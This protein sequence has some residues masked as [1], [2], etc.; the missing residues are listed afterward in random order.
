MG[1]M[2]LHWLVRKRIKESGGLLVLK[3]LGVV[4]EGL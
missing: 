3:L 2:N 4:K 1:R